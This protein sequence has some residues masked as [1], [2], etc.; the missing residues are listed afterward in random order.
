MQ[1]KVQNGLSI[2]LAAEE[3]V[4]VFGEQLKLSCITVVPQAY[5]RM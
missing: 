2:L 5:R 1:R 3:D 4:R